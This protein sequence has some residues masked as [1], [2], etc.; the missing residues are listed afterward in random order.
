MR[1][2]LLFAITCA[3]LAACAAPPP[4]ATAADAARSGV[5]LDQLSHG[6]QLLVAKCSG[7]HTTPVPVQ[8]T[9][10]DWPVKIDEMAER[11]HLDGEQRRAI[12]TY[13]VA[14]TR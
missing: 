2:A 11:S 12:E 9:A 1:A 8:H 10:S 4:V 6:R 3:G 5:A 13:L 7:C 14:M